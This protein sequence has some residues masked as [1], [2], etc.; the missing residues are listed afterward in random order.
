M[1][2]DPQLQPV[3]DLIGGELRVDDKT[4]E[5]AR[6][7]TSQA[8]VPLDMTGLVSADDIEVGGA[9]GKLAARVYRPEGA[10][11][12]GPVIV[13]FHGGGWV[14][15]SIASHD[16]TAGRMA[17]ESGCTVV[18]VEYRLAPEHKFPAPLEDC[19]AATVWVAEH[20]AELGVDAGR[21][22]VAGDSAGG[23]LAAALCL[24]ARERGGPAISFQLLIYPV[25][26]ITFDYP[27]HAEN[28]PL[29]YILSGRA[30]RWF[31]DHYVGGAD[32]VDW[33]AAPI[34]AEDLSGLPPAMIVTAE[35]DPLRDEGEEYA[36]R[37]EDAGVPTTLIRGA[38]MIHGF[39]GFPVDEGL[40]IRKEVAAALRTAL[41]V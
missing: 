10:A 18:S 17:V 23:N 6:A 9:D 28:G 8:R 39:Y 41:R 33:R 13:F 29:N 32:G 37:L 2:L 36:R 14:I 11:A 31:T 38:G 20:A 4:P 40:R 12:G 35:L 1:P 24:L 7:F 26:D 21:L 5:E 15:G 19:Y 3:L 16:N 27:S 34:Q 25:T 30:M 22:A